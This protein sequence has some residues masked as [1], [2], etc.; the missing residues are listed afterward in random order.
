MPKEQDVARLQA[1]LRRAAPA[2]AGAPRAPP[3]WAT[4]AVAQI[5]AHSLSCSGGGF[6]K[7]WSH[8]VQS[9]A[10]LGLADR[11]ARAH[12]VRELWWRV[13]AGRLTAERGS[14][15]WEDARDPP[16]P[17]LSAGCRAAPAADGLRN[18]A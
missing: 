17:N 1:G 3:S 9:W 6:R 14:Q 16:V 4:G 15:P 7:T 12:H 11:G 10:S 13:A 5:P 18:Q 8:Q 2:Q